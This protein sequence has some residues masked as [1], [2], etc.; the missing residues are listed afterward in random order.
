MIKVSIL[1]PAF[2]RA[3]FLP[4]MLSSI[5]RQEPFTEEIEWETWIIDNG[6][7]DDTRELVSDWSLRWPTLH[8]SYTFLPHPGLTNA[9]NQGLE[10]VTGDY[11]F[12]TDS[13]DFW[14][15]KKLRM[16][17]GALRQAHGKTIAH[18]DLRV[19]NADGTQ[20]INPSLHFSRF[21]NKI[22]TRFEDILQ[23]TNVWAGTVLLHRSA[24]RDLIPIPISLRTQDPWIALVGAFQERLVVVPH[25]LYNYRQHGNGQTLSLAKQRGSSVPGL[26]DHIELLTQ[27]KTRYDDQLNASQRDAVVH[28]LYWLK[29]ELAIL[30]PHANPPVPPEPSGNVALKN[31]IRIRAGVAKRIF[32][33]RHLPW[34]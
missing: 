15:P 25:V 23:R 2:N 24:I 13:D 4:D 29:R 27:F 21:H 14:D 26:F 11:V 28:R 17:L 3:Q 33:A 5:A 16:Q 8:L 22:S 20:I 1:I 10:L 31:R 18:T 34:V 9:L 32:L 6:S 7:T 12:L 30:W 19:V